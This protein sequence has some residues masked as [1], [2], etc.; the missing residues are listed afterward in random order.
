[1]SKYC[2]YPHPSS[3]NHGCEAIAVSTVNIL[4]KW[5]Q[6]SKTVLLTKFAKGSEHRGEDFAYNLYNDVK[7]MQMPAIKRYSLN[8]FV[9][10]I[11]RIFNKDTALDIRKKKLLRKHADIFENNDIFVS[12]GGD[13]YC[14]GKPTSFYAMNEVAKEKGNK[15]V[16]WGCS[17]EPDAMDDDMVRDLKR[18]NVIVARESLTYDAMISKGINNVKLYPDPAFTLEK[19][20]TDEILENTVGINISPMILNYA[21]DSD[22]AFN[23]YKKLAEYILTET[24]CNIALIPHVTEIT[25]NDIETL[26]RLKTEL[27]DNERITLYGDMDCTKLK[28]LIS[29]CRIFIGARTHATI[30]AYSTCVPTLVCGYSVKA[31]GIAKDIFGTYENYVVPVQEIKNTDALKDAFLWIMEREDSIKKYLEDFMPG[32][33]QKAWDAGSELINV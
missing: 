30:A 20:E 18:Y 27:A 22:M 2:F 14:Y 7:V 21:N 12:I 32:Y 31:K 23:A 24:D 5:K 17:V 33:I 1:M 3:K 16:L 10:H 15:T 25:T 19:G 8:W 26:Q 6:D 13:N 4:K 11:N 9:Y 28:A 29:Q